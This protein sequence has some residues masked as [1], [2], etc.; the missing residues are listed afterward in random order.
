MRALSQRA[1]SQSFNRVC[2]LKRFSYLKEK[3][4][5]QENEG[6]VDDDDDDDVVRMYEYVC[7]YVKF[8]IKKVTT[9][10]HKHTSR[11]RESDI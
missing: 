2:K 8:I 11:E 3:K 5:K 6:Y 4:N 10:S 7:C 9:I 1:I